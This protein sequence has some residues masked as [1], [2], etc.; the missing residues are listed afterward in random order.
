M[1][2][3]DDFDLKAFSYS[4]RALARWSAVRRSRGT[5]S[6]VSMCMSPTRTCFN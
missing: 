3:L 1:A 4:H 6:T 5:V 2:D